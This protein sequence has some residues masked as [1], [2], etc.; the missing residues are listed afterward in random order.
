MPGVV[1]P[2]AGIG[3]P[4]APDT[5][6]V[7]S[8][9][10]TNLDPG[11]LVAPVERDEEEPFEPVSKEENLHFSGYIHIKKEN[12]SDDVTKLQK[13]LNTFEGEKLDIDGTYK[14]SDLE[15]VQR[16]QLK[17]TEF[18]LAPWGIKNPTGYVYKTTLKMIHTILDAQ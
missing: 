18:I 5:R 15:A 8:L 2:D 1:Y 4:P 3:T 14:I 12:N 10:T 16:F 7:P 17:Y 13:F 11:T 9:E 6:S